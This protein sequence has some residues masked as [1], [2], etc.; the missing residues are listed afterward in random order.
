MHQRDDGEQLMKWKELVSGFHQER[1]NLIPRWYSMGLTETSTSYSL[2]GFSD[3]SICS[4][5]VLKSSNFKWLSG[6]TFKF[7]TRVSPA[8]ERTIPR[9]E[10]LAALLLARLLSCVESAL[11][12]EIHLKPPI[13]YTDLKVALYW[14]KGVSRE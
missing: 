10:L 3:A 9:L 6:P 14:I 2:H 12:E 4:S 1:P 8:K 13:C 11:M 7:E 5:G